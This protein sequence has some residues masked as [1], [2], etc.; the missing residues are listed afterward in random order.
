MNRPETVLDVSFYHPLIA[1]RGVDEEPHLLDGVLRSAPG[2]ES[3]RGRA[4]VRLE[5]RL[6]HELGRRLHDPVAH[7]RDAQ[8]SELPRALRDQPL[9]RRQRTVGAILE[10]RTEP[11]E[12][13]F[14][15]HL[16]DNAAGLTIDTGGPGPPVAFHPFPRDE[17]RRGSQTRLNRSPKRRC[18]SWAAHRCSLVCH[19]STRSSA[20]F[21]SSGAGV[22][23]PDLP[24]SV[25]C[26]GPAVRLRHVDGFPA[27]GLLR[28][29]RHAQRPSAG[30]GH[31]RAATS[32][33][34]RTGRLPRSP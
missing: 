27:L 7:R 8:G 6:E 22:F 21:A 34:A 13:T 16:L 4:K 23:T 25:S 17:Q 28:G 9:T 20:N 14:H 19:P 18:S 31:S 1:A 5:D 11:G 26:H 32:G 2:P 15:A 12:D 3:V 33:R 30:I 10:L 24:N 29:L